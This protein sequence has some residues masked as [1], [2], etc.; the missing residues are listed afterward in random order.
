MEEKEQTVGKKEPEFKVNAWT[1]VWTVIGSVLSWIN[2]LV[3]YY[4][5]EVW[6][7]L[8]IIPTTIILGVIISYKNR[9]CG[10]GFLIGFAIAGILFMLLIDP[11]IGAYTALT[12]L[13]IFIFLWLIFWKTWRSISSIKM[14]KE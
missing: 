4:S 10:Y 1:L 14:I 8:S 11:F 3:I 9:Y 7:Y 6:S 2:M 5:M 12:T 13:F